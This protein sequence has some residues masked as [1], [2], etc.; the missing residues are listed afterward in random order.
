MTDNSPTDILFQ[1]LTP[2]GVLVRTT[3]SH[4]QVITTIKH[5][6]I[7]GKEALIKKALENPVEIRTSKKDQNIYLYYGNDPPYLICVV[8]RHLNGEGFIITAYR[9]D[10]MKLGEIVWTP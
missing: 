3:V 2:L 4:W 1:V 8:V 7:L 5:P 9:T 6:K 10:K